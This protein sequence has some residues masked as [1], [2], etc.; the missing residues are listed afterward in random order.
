[1]AGMSVLRGAGRTRAG[2]PTPTREGSARGQREGPAATLPAVDARTS[3]RSGPDRPLAGPT[4]AGA[5]AVG[6]RVIAPSR[7]PA[8]RVALLVAGLVV[9]LAGAMLA[10]SPVAAHAALAATTPTDGDRVQA[11]PA[12]V[13]LVF[14]EGVS[15]TL[16]AVRVLDA[17]GDRVDR[18]SV[19]A[20]GDRVTVALRDD[21][22]DGAYIVAWRV[23]SA[24][25]HPIKGS[26]TFNVGDVD[27]RI[28]QTVLDAIAGGDGDGPWRAAGS[29]TRLFGYGGALVAVG[30]GVF[31][32]FVHRG[33]DE[34][35]RLRRLLRAAAVVGAV[36]VLAE[37]PVRAALA[38]GLGP[39]ALTAPGVL[40]QLLADNVGV[41]MAVT[42]L[43]LLFVSVD[44]GGDRLIAAGCTVAV[45]VAVAV[46]GHTATTSPLALA[47][48]ADAVHVAA[49][50]VWVGGL[51]GGLVVVVAARGRGSGAWTEVVVRF[52]GVAGVSL[53]AV[54]LAGAALGWTQVR[55]LEA[56]VTTPYGRLLLAKVAVVG[57]VALL[58]G[59]NRYRLVPLLQPAA[60]AD[61]A[62]VG[63]HARV[64]R[65]LRRTLAAEVALLALVIGLAA[66]LVDVTPARAS[67]AAP[68]F[69]SE[70]LGEGRAEVDIDP[71]RTGRTTMHIYLYDSAGDSLEVAEGV[72]VRFSLP[73]A[74]IEGLERVPLTTGPGHYTLVG[75]DLSISGTWVVE[76][77]ART[78]LYDEDTARFEVAIQP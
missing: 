3:R 43:A 28:D 75:D 30:L 40:D 49:A 47:V 72:K 11:S 63:D 29:L 76:L 4:T 44:G 70:P 22:A 46:S 48:G 56:L 25:S 6:L 8:R 50:A 16:G 38:T 34:R 1:M 77:V 78:S 68:F 67:V 71:T 20:G 35:S 37:L 66:V 2:G 57:A 61:S 23:V 39:D 9:V 24:D 27:A 7:R 5:S 58:G 62:V 54:T 69:G 65:L 13:D 18:G 51:V 60:D 15:A 10:P 64:G 17:S 31:A 33:D 26:F 73:S 74:D 42:L 53:A 41:S 14:T 59:I 36:G 32:S 12:Q 21:L 19:D 52:S 55:S 45:G